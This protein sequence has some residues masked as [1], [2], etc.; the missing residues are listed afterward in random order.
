MHPWLLAGAV[1]G[2]TCAVMLLG[3]WGYRRLRRRDHGSDDLDYAIQYAA[4][5][6]TLNSL[7]L[8]FMTVQVWE[9]HDAADGAA[10]NEATAIERAARDLASYGG[11]AA[12]AVRGELKQYGRCVVD[13]EWPLL[14]QQRASTRCGAELDDVSR[15]LGALEPRPGRQTVLLGKIWD[16]ADEVARFRVERLQASGSS[17]PRSLWIVVIFATAL[18]FASLIV[19][20]A[21]RFSH[22]MLMLVAACHGAFLF[23]IIHLNQPFVGRDRVSPDALQDVVEGMDRW[24]QRG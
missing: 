15:T 9:A 6:A 22:A 19:M 11:R 23:F 21:T 2:G 5:L 3:H 16:R 1:V 7:L 13:E 14:A 24:D 17:V 4:I 18:T 8:A 12:A 20:P 10:L